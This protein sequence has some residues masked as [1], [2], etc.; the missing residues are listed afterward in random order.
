MNLA[1]NQ[2]HDRVLENNKIL[3]TRSFVSH[4]NMIS[5]LV[6]QIE[7]VAHQRF[8][9]SYYSHI[10][11]FKGERDEGEIPKTPNTTHTRS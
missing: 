2:S 10:K 1:P 5:F 4:L 9:T 11:P 6:S 7:H 8:V 3:L